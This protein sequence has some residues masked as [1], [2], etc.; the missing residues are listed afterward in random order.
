M[1]THSAARLADCGYLIFPTV[2]LTLV[3]RPRNVAVRNYGQSHRLRLEEGFFHV[4]RRLDVDVAGNRRVRSQCCTLGCGQ[5]SPRSTVAYAQLNAPAA[6]SAKGSRR[7][8]TAA[9]L[10]SPPC[11]RE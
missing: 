10:R 2:D 1:P 11:R 9:L 6:L 7:S 3:Y 5:P 8:W 4:R